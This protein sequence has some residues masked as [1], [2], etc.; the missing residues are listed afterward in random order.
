MHALSEE[1][2]ISPTG[3]LEY[4]TATSLEPKP[5]EQDELKRNTAEKE[6]GRATTAKRS[7]RVLVAKVIA[8]CLISL[9][10]LLL[11]L[12]ML[13][14]KI[15]DECVCSAHEGTNDIKPFKHV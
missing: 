9:A 8:V 3:A 13:F 15:G 2:S 10:A 4:D 12:L 5:L 14:G 7:H 1:S 11:A 6:S